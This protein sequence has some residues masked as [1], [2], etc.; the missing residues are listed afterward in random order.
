MC[1]LYECPCEGVVACKLTWRLEEDIRCSVPS[2]PTLLLSLN[3]EEA[4][5]EQTLAILL[6]LSPTELG[7]EAPMAF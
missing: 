7:L 4:N 5:R 3:L 6:S 2:F 1:V